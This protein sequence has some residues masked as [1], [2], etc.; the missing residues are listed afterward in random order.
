MKPTYGGISR[1]GLIAFA[2]SLDQIGPLARTV[3]DAA[4]VVEAVGGHD[5]FDSTSL[6]RTP[7]DLRSAPSL[8]TEGLRVGVVGDFL[9]DAQPECAAAVRA[10]A[11]ALTKEGAHVDEV[12]IPE[13]MLGLPAYYLIAPAEASSN[14]ARYDGVRYGLRVDAAD[15]AEMNARTRAAGFGAEVKRRIMLGTYVL[16]AG[17]Y[18]A[19][20][21]QAQRVR[22]L[23][24]RGVRERVRELRRAVGAHD[25]V[26]RVRVRS[27]NRRSRGDVPVG[28][29]HDPVESRRSPGD[30]RA[31]HP[32]GR[33][34]DR[35]PGPRAGPRGEGDVPG[36][37]GARALG[38]PFD[39]WPIEPNLA[40][41]R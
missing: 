25:P 6:D 8:P 40:T 19:Y 1:F 36:G 17:Y 38:G 34:A 21:A 4:A 30:Q 23:V 10:A 2:S 35:R 3:E 29:V 9:V 14:L 12:A 16:S 24:A 37:R 33:S 27:E 39:A 11:D 15:A 20:Y 13:L 22:T 31:V 26:R 18:D 28:S 41:S 5:P 32:R 7:D